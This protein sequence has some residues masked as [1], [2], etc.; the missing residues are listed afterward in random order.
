MLRTPFLLL[1]SVIF[2]LTVS[3]SG[4][5]LA[6][7]V[8][9]Y[10]LRLHHRA[11]RYF[12]L[13]MVMLFPIPAYVYS[14]AWLAF[15]QKIGVSFLSG[16]VGSWWI[17]VISL[18]PIAILLS[19]VGFYSINPTLI[20]ASRIARPGMHTFLRVMLPLAFP[21][22]FAAA[23]FLFVLSITDYSV[24]SLFS[25]SVYSLEIFA[26]YSASSNALK[27]T[28]LALPL[29]GI[30]SIVIIASQ[31]RLKNAVLHLVNRDLNLRL[32]TFPEWFNWL[33]KVCAVGVVVVALVLLLNL[34]A[35]V[36]SITRLITT[37]RSAKE[38]ILFSLWCAGMSA[39]I[40]IVPAWFV[41]K[42]LVKENRISWLWWLIVVLPLAIPS[43]LVGIGLISLFNREAFGNFYGSGWMPVLVS[44]VRFSPVA[45][46]IL[47]S[48]LRRIDRTQLD[49]VALYQ[50]NSLHGW[51]QIKLRM[52]APGIFAALLITF[53]LSLGELGGT[54]MV[55]PPGK[56]T[57]SM[58]IY[59][60]MH[61]GASS[62]VA[63]LC[64]V[65]ALC[66]LL[67]AGLALLAMKKKG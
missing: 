25:K 54:L 11:A 52:Y 39:L 30:S 50:K 55:A 42:Q 35:S 40:S 15:T 12:S 32:I 28:L 59:N 29:L 31:A 14:L 13:L 33:Q 18:L 22:L 17:Q 48:Q 53:A 56:S 58:R 64:L 10:L 66:V 47:M 3:L 57:L 67:C 16:W 23:G 37:V 2:G 46:L 44:V 63:G 65:V 21:T 60:Y 24:P 9:L 36:E 62:E 4:M 19:L 27:A 7:M 26:E 8:A 5:I 6:I 41:G 38:E 61:Y 20:E 45:A 51:R 34:L 43:S 49:A 1:Q